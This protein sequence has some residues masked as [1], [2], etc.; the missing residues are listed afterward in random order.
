MRGISGNFQQAT[1]IDFIPFLTFLSLHFTYSSN[2]F[3]YLDS[4]ASYIA[5]SLLSPT[6]HRLTIKEGN[7]KEYMGTKNLDSTYRTIFFPVRS[8]ILFH[9]VTFRN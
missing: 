9:Y 2:M 5:N 8:L 4:I 7:S 6:N 3:T 1:S